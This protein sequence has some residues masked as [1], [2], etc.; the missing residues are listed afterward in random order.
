MYLLKTSI[1]TRQF[2]SKGT[3]DEAILDFIL[4]YYALSNEQFH[5]KNDFLPREILS[6]RL[7]FCEKTTFICHKKNEVSIFHLY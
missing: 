5:F 2:H 6:L 3:G 1:K 7:H 4:T